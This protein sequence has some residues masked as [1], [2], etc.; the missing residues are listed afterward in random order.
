M[1]VSFKK[2]EIYWTDIKRRFDDGRFC[3]D[4]STI[5]EILVSQGNYRE[6][7]VILIFE[8]LV[9]HAGTVT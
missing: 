1:N 5:M 2:M 7:G 9:G 8:S 4:G 6:R 3:H